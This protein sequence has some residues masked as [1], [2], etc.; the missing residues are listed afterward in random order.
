MAVDDALN[1]GQSYSGAFK[2]FRQMQTLKDAEQL[3]YVLHVKASAVVP[4]EHLD[5]FFIAVD[6]ANLDFGRPSHACEFGR[7]GNKVD[8]DQPQHGT[9]SVTDRKRADLP[10]NVPTLRVLPD[11]RDDLLDELLQVHRRLF[12]FG[13]LKR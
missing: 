1:G 4:H 2:L 9:V 12:G 6:T 8:N 10:S 11:F 13:P 7:V 3:V 5:F